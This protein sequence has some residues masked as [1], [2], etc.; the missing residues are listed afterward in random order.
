MID[1]DK[2]LEVWNRKKSVRATSLETGVPC[3]RIRRILVDKGIL[4]TERDHQI[5]DMF[6]R[7]LSREEIAD[8][9]NVKATTVDAH[10]P[11]KRGIYLG[12]SNTTRW[13]QRKLETEHILE[14][15]NPSADRE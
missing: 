7:G 9:L 13:R 10:S 6:S 4:A 15:L 12:S 8:N 1:I 2:I 11:Y 3:A 5:H 14:K